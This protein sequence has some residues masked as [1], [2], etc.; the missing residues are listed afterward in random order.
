M[1]PIMRV[2]FEG[3]QYVTQDIIMSDV[4]FDT[5]RVTHTVRHNVLWG[6]YGQ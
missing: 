6:G 1:R 4:L 3:A 2:A 5:M